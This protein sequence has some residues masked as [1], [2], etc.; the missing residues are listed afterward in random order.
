MQ[1]PEHQE[2]M[3]KNSKYHSREYI[4]ILPFSNPNPN[5]NQNQNHQN[6]KRKKGKNTYHTVQNQLYIII[7]SSNVTC[8]RLNIAMWH[9]MF[10]HTFFVLYTHIIFFFILR[11]KVRSC[12]LWGCLCLVSYFPSAIRIRIWIRIRII[13]I[14][15][16]RKEKIPTILCKINST[17]F[18]NYAHDFL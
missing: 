17:M 12:S 8:S 1:P 11:L 16:G 18:S 5:L 10:V 7:I 13:R 15:R 4:V 3:I 2:A 14:R 6:Q 9:L